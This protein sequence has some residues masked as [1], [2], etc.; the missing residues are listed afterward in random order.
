MLT[1]KITEVVDLKKKLVS[2]AL[3]AAMLL[4]PAAAHESIFAQTSMTASAQ[5]SGDWEYVQAEQKDCIRLTGYKGNETALKIPSKIGSKKVTELGAGLFN[6]NEKLKSAVVPN[7]VTAIGGSAFCGCTQLREV[8]LPDSITS[9]GTSDHGYVFL[10]CTKLEKVNIPSK[11]TTLEEG[12]FEDC[13]SLKSAKLPESLKAIKYACFADC[14]SLVSISIP[15]SVTSIGRFAFTDC[16][17]LTKFTVDEKNISYCST[18]GVLYNKAMTKLIAF[19]AKMSSL[20]IPSSVYMIEQAAFSENSSL[21]TAVIPSTVSEIG[22]RAFYRCSK[23]KNILVNDAN[24]NFTSHDG[25]LYNKDATQLICCPAG[26]TGILTVEPTIERIAPSAFESSSL[27]GIKLP[28]T[29]LQ[30]G[31]KAFAGSCIT[32]IVIPTDCKSIGSAA[33]KGC[34]ALVQATISTGVATVGSEAFAN[35]PKLTQIFVPSSV[36]SIGQN[37]FGASDTSDSWK[38]SPKG[39]VLYCDDDS[40]ALKHAKSAGL[41]YKTVPAYSRLAGDN[42]FATAAR[43]SQSSF[44]TA[45]TV[46]LAFGYNSAD[47]LAGVPLAAKLG[48][49]ILLTEKNSLPEETSSEIKRLGAKQVIILGGVNAIAESVE[50]QLRKSG[51]SVEREAGETRFGTAVGIAKRLEKLSGSKPTEVFFVNAYQ[52]ADALSASAAAATKSAPIIY[53]SGKGEPDDETA[54]YLKSIKDSVKSAYIIGGTGVITDEALTAAADS[55]GLSSGEAASR[56]WGADRYATCTAVNERFAD[57][58][59]GSSLCTA[60]GYDFPDALAGGVFAAIKKA[61]LFLADNSLSDVQIKYLQSR[62]TDSISI[63]GGIN[64]VPEKLSQQISMTAA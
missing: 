46:V 44:K 24:K 49:P 51:L 63:F 29:L 25:V 12:T 22:D 3:A 21:T 48:A 54:E 58:L 30:I 32:D 16:T 15:S 18:G 23:L 19:P 39:F 33:F 47:A 57:V 45:K 34:N 27:C 26:K 50:D 4:A 9:L 43:I 35:C 2:L 5:T 42:R 31:E 11:L 53:L 62:K 61:P 17:S 13:T 56:I 59:D 10:G 6:A 55:L 38:K 64:A 14:K 36:T 37:A 40:F 60:K 7:T 41:A 28:G 20:S 8:T 1:K 52:F